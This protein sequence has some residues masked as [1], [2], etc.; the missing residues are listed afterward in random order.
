MEFLDNRNVSSLRQMAMSNLAIT[1]CRDPEILDFVKCNGCS[2]F[3]FPS[4]ET[5]FYL[6]VKSPAKEIWIWKDF[7]M[8]EIIKNLYVTHERKNEANELDDCVTRKNILPFAR[9]EELVVGRISSF[10]LPQLLQHELLEVIRSVSIEIEK[11][12]KDHFLFLQRSADIAYMAQCHFQWDPMGKID[13]LKTANKLIMNEGLYI[14]DRCI[15][16]VHY[17][18]TEKISIRENVLDEVVKKYEKF[19]WRG[20]RADYVWKEFIGDGDCSYVAQQNFFPRASPEQKVLCLNAVMSKASLQYNEF[21]FYLSQ[22]GDD[23]RKEVFKTHAF[24]ILE[25]YFLDWPLQYK[26][27]EVA[28]Q[29][30]PYF[31]ESNFRNMLR[32][33]L[34]EKIMLRRKDFNYVHLLKEFWSL[35]SSHLKESIKTDSIYE[36]LM[37]AINFPVCE[38]FPNE[39]LF[40]SYD[41]GCLTFG[42]C[43]IKYCLFREEKIYKNWFLSKDFLYCF[44]CRCVNAFVFGKNH[45]HRCKKERKV[46]RKE[47]FF[48]L[49]AILGAIWLAKCTLCSFLQ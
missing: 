41:G 46:V 27:S 23:E 39:Q 17:G 33:I 5:H 47:H 32:I 25:Q 26:F 1:V 35:S 15:L 6:E 12:I 11:W 42:C 7:L 3:V 13:R 22:M 45:P 44:H 2:S 9:W 19:P 34:F 30:L 8:E 21:V 14:E 40:K 18:L 31:S 29:L 4:K 28:E 16:A 38:N 49:G 24:K 37:F 10:L 48:C 20:A 36:P 43:G